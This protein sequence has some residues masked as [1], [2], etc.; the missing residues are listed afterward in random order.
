[1]E[2]VIGRENNSPRFENLTLFDIVNFFVVFE[3]KIDIYGMNDAICNAC[4]PSEQSRLF[5]YARL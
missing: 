4:T 3:K 1:M 2:Q 5:P